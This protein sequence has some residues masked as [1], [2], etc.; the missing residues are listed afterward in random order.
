MPKMLGT[1]LAAK[2]RIIKPELKVIIITGYID[3][4]S[5]EII[6]K[7]GISE[8]IMKPLKLSDFSKIIRKVLDEK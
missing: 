5:E 2:M 6:N 8:V 4:I 3:K 1:K 7:N